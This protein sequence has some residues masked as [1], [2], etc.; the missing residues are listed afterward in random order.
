MLLFNKMA[1]EHSQISISIATILKVVAVLVLFYFA[2]RIADIILVLLMAIVIASAVEPG[3]KWFEKRKI[4]RVPAVVTIYIGAAFVLL[5]IFYFI[6]LPFV[7][8]AAQF[9]KALPDYSQ[10]IAQSDAVQTGALSSQGI[11]GGL[12]ESLS[13]SDLTTKVNSLVSSFSTGFFAVIQYVFGGLLSFI[14]IIVLSFYLAVQKDGVGKFLRVV[15]PAQYEEYTIDLWK[16]SRQKIGLWMQGQLL[17]GVIVAVLTF[18][19]LTLLQVPNALLLAVL[20]GVFELIPLFGPILSA[21][22]A[23]LIAFVSKGLTLT[24]IVAAFYL[25]V[26]QFENH[27]IYPQ[28]VKKVVGIS[29]IVSILALV[30]GGKIAG[31]LGVLLAVPLATV[32]IELL[33]DLEKSKG[34]DT[35][36]S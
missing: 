33:A 36:T 10:A 31:F 26:Q 6:L 21:I 1:K 20:A 3:T 28:V 9:L 13:L 29:P 8:E 30:I 27:L 2:W 7:S 32:I 18:L 12:S 35:R 4:P 17:L 23:L 11:L 24:I 22:P 5:L 15:I 25:I 14:L 16:R 34:A 19:G